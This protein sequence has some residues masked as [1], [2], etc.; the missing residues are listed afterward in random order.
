MRERRAIG[1]GKGMGS[2]AR[3]R[4]GW[5]DR[6]G[7]VDQRDRAP[8][9]HRDRLGAHRGGYRACTGGPRSRSFSSTEGSTAPTLPVHVPVHDVGTTSTGG[10][11]ASSQCV[12]PMPRSR[13]DRGR[14][15]TAAAPTP[16]GCSRGRPKAQALSDEDR[17]GIAGQLTPASGRAGRRGC[18]QLWRDVGYPARRSPPVAQAHPPRRTQG[19]AD[20]GPRRDRVLS[21]PL[22]GRPGS[23]RRLLGGAAPR[24]PLAGG[25]TAPPTRSPGTQGRRRRRGVTWRV[26][27][28]A[29][30]NRERSPKM[31]STTTRPRGDR[32]AASEREQ[33]EDAAEPAGSRRHRIGPGWPPHCDGL[34]ASQDGGTGTS[35][36]GASIPSSPT[37]AT[38]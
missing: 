36:P 11:R 17:V 8:G 10:P 33:P 3:S 31:S 35:G 32:C 20:D 14:P 22:P 2:T 9:Q 13:P 24:R 18:R 5:L 19:S 28:I 7:P 38:G 37:S 27:A 25:G 6:R 34:E 15:L 4:A 26:R 30:G 16:S 1:I 23:P 29:G 12:G 21:R